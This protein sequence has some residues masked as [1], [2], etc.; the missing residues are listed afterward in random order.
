MTGDLGDFFL[1]MLGRPPMIPVPPEDSTAGKWKAFALELERRDPAAL[2]VLRTF[3]EICRRSENPVGG[4][5]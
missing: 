3:S 4:E 5:N 2:E 1:T